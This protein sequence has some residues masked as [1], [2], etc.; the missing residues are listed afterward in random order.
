M[1]KLKA[2]K[3]VA[4]LKQGDKIKV[5][6]REWEVDDQGITLDH[7]DTKEMYIDIFDEEKDEDAQLRYFDDQVESSLEF[8]MLKNEFLYERQDIENVEW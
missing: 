2:S 5:D 6:G 8:Y 7:G 4:E 1:V 3:P